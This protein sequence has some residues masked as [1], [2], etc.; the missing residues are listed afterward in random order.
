[1]ALTELTT[2]ELVPLVQRGAKIAALGY[3]DIIAPLPVIRELL[4]ELK[5]SMLRFRMDSEK[6][7]KWH[8]LEMHEIPDSESFFELFGAHLD[9]FDIYPTRGTEIICDLNNPFPEKVGGGGSPL[10]YYDFVLDIGTLEHCF[11]IGQAALNAAGLLKQGGIIFHSNPYVS[12]NHG[13]YGLN[14]TWYADFYTQPGF[15]L[16]WVKL[17]AKGQY[18][19]MDVPLTKRFRVD[20][21]DIDIF[22]AAKRTEIRAVTYPMQ[23]KYVVLAAADQPGARK[24]A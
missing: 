20:S 24:T 7:C 6:I 13:F 23:H 4:G 9:V 16:M 2:R 3:P 15:E 11:N 12:G 1:M 22:A 17:K 5:Y 8:G 21:A 19:A 10:G 14:P 18:E